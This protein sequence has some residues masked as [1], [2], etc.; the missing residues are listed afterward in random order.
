G[1]DTIR[2]I[3]QAHEFGLGRSGEQALVGLLVNEGTV[4]DLGHYVSQGL[5]LTTAFYQYYD[6]QTAKWGERFRAR[7]GQNASMYT[8]SVYSALM[9]YFKAVQA[10]DSDEAK[11]VIAKMREMPV[12]DFFARNGKLREDG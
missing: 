2:A 6:A 7:S 10:T 8:A 1:H 5:Q 3:Q 11:T 12:N 9:H 4:R